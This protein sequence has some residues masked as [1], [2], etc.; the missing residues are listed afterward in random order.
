M[1]RVNNT[2]AIKA[3]KARGVIYM[4]LVR[5]CIVVSMAKS[6]LVH[7]PGKMPSFEQE[8]DPLIPAT[9][10]G[11]GCYSEGLLQ[12]IDWM[13][14]PSIQNRPQNVT[15]VMSILEQASELEVPRNTEDPLSKQDVRSTMATV[16]VTEKDY[17]RASEKISIKQGDFSY[18]LETMQNIPKLWWVILS[19]CI[20]I[21]IVINVGK[22]QPIDHRGELALTQTETSLQS[23]LQTKQNQR[24]HEEMK[25]QGQSILNNKQSLHLPRLQV[26]NPQYS[27]SQKLINTLLSE[28]VNDIEQLRLTSPKGN[29]AFDKY[30]Q[31]LR[32][33]S[34]NVA[35]QQ[36]YTLIVERYLQLAKNAQ[37]RQE[38][39]RATR[40]I[41]KARKV[42]PGSPK[43]YQAKRQLTLAQTKK[44]I[45]PVE[46][47]KQW[48]PIGEISVF[49]KTIFTP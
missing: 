23:R 5:L 1:R 46:Q 29:N 20:L 17:Q 18:S 15:Q 11:E 38:Y 41:N 44:E 6:P 21:L 42:Q 12:L 47:E 16:V 7:P 33:D 26:N 13:L 39:A 31:V 43:I 2:V 9:I 36:G 37:Y 30:Q 40:L 24:A 10:I 48:K 3:S 19:I 49:F 45:P 34:G 35:V 32:L 25:T 8:P 27:A 14:A 4:R 22:N 28:A